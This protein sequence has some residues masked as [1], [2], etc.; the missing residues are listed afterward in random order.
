MGLRMPWRHLIQSD[1]VVVTSPARI[2][3]SLSKMKLWFWK[4]ERDILKACSSI[5]HLREF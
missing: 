3:P 1:S 4:C 2:F 5:L